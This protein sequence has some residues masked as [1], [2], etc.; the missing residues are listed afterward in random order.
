VSV[1]KTISGRDYFEQEN[2]RIVFSREYL[3]ARG[4]CCGSDCLN[5]PFKF[6]KTKNSLQ[7]LDQRPVISMVPSWTETL[8]CA[9]ANVVGRTRFC[10]HPAES[11][12]GIQVL[13][14][15][16][17]VSSNFKE[18][19]ALIASQRDQSR[20]KPLVI[21][22]KEENP[23]DFEAIFQGAGCDTL[24]T[25]VRSLGA[26]KS[27]LQNLATLFPT[28][29]PVSGTLLHYADRLEALLMR[30][31]QSIQHKTSCASSEEGFGEALIK[32]FVS[33]SST[34]LSKTYAR[35]KQ[36]DANLVY[37]IWKSPWMCV[38]PGTFIES[39]LKWILS[40]ASSSL[41]WIGPRGEGKYP[42]FDL[43]DVPAGTLLVY[44]SEPYP[45]EKELDRLLPGILVDGEKISWFGIRSIRYLE[46]LVGDLYTSPKAACGD[47]S[48]PN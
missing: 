2:G 24:A 29:S 47:E 26:F 40:G 35:L 30:P 28:G 31:T 19:M 12:R 27:E 16:K 13:G 37:L 11:V 10:I 7:D 15:T 34:P 38:G 39:V 4:T 17:N 23:K 21:L 3:F 20:L 48:K 5:C 42:E 36:G 18:A 25:E 14:G 1:L 45:F 43:E 33:T 6:D 8:I 22:D 46:N 44:S 41:L 32:D 9:G